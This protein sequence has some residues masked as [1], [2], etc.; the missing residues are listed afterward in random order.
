MQ[1]IVFIVSWLALFFLFRTMALRKW[2]DRRGEQIDITSFGLAMVCALIA[3]RILL[4]VGD[5]PA[6][7]DFQAELDRLRA[8]AKVMPEGVAF[9]TAELNGVEVHEV[10]G[11]EHAARVAFVRAA[12]AAPRP[13]LALRAGTDR[14]QRYLVILRD[15]IR[16]V[17]QR[18]VTG[19]RGEREWVQYPL[20]E[21]KLESCAARERDCHTVSPDSAPVDDQHYR[22]AGRPHGSERFPVA[23]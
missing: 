5:R 8:E 4:A 10:R 15:T 7:P 21:V 9:D 6:G 16:L 12:A 19:S 2:P 23:F 22:L 14:S 18:E 1:I 13:A 11:S 3:F 20:E 17:M